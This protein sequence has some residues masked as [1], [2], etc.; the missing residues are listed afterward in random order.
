MF[1]VCVCRVFDIVLFSLCMFASVLLL[2]VMCCFLCCFIFG[3]FACCLLFV[4]CGVCLLLIALFVVPIQSD[5][6]VFNGVVCWVVLL[7][8]L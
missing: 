5:W 4:F 2:C 3:V 7:F 8:V 1:D 6:Y